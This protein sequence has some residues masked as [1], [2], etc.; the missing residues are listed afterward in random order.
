MSFFL[1]DVKVPWE[2]LLIRVQEED[3]KKKNHQKSIRKRNYRGV[4][5]PPFFFPIR[6][7]KTHVNIYI[8]KHQI[9]NFDVGNQET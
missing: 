7:V 5:H 8:G 2:L 9:K 6:F 1:I 3:G 4:H